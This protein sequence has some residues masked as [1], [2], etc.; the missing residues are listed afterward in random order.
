MAPLP[1][2]LM[3]VYNECVLLLIAF[4][5]IY[6]DIINFIF[7]LLLQS[8]KFYCSN[9]NKGCDCILNFSTLSSHTHICTKRMV[10]CENSNVGCEEKVMAEKL[11]DHMK[12]CPFR[13]VSCKNKCQELITFRD[14]D[15]HQES[16]P[17]AIVSCC[18]CGTSMSRSSQALH[19]K[20]SCTEIEIC[21]SVPGCPAKMKR[22]DKQRHE[23]ESYIS[24]I[25]C[26]SQTAVDQAKL[27][28]KLTSAKQ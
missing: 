20:E 19:L 26:L 16:C 12:E 22:K 5:K 27:I 23:T 17:M 1:R 8:L 25:R 10:S 11:A 14:V 4:F 18:Y 15:K 13:L 28:A 24:H 3:S 21:C 6:I 2:L 7:F 9:R